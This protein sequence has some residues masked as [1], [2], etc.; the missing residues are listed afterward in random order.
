MS[1]L[2][3]RALLKAAGVSLSLPLLESMSPAWGASANAPPKRMVL[4]CTAL[5]LHPPN[6]WPK[7]AGADYEMTPY[8]KLLKEHRQDYT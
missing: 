6:L 3:R 1:S 5:G 4:L 8:L 7:T 2:N